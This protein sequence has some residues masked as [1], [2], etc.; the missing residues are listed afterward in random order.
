M[1]QLTLATIEPSLPGVSDNGLCSRVLIVG[2]M[3]GLVLPVVGL[4][5]GLQVSPALARLLL[6][7]VSL[8]SGVTGVIPGDSTTT[9]KVLFLFFSGLCW[10]LVFYILNSVMESFRK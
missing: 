2:F 5:I 3:L 8:L 7:P 4:F 6:W 10:A 1:L 9:E